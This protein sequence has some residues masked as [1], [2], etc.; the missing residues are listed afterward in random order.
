MTAEINYK[1]FINYDVFVLHIT[2][3]NSFRNHNQISHE[4]DKIFS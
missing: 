2:D 3:Y 1:N 4:E